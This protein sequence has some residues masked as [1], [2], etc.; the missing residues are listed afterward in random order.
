MKNKINAKHILI[1]T[2]IVSSYFLFLFLNGNYHFVEAKSFISFFVELLTIPFILL[3]LSIT[4]YC[5]IS[6]FVRREK[7]IALLISLI[8]SL[9]TLISMFLIK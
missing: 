7:K 9:I 2:V 4:I 6:Y 1:L 3:E 8:L 5:F